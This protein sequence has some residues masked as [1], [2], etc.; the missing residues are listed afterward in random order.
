MQTEAIKSVPIKF[1]KYQ[2]VEDADCQRR[3]IAARNKLGKRLVILGHHYQHESVYRDA[4]SRA[5]H[6][7]AHC[8]LYRAE[9]RRVV[10]EHLTVFEMRGRLAV[11]D[12]DYLLV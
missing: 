2:A 8:F 5:A 3:I 12:N 11:G 6:Y 1:E 7:L 10:E 9:C 4:V